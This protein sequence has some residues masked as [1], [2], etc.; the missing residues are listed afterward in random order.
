MIFQGLLPNFKMNFY[1][2]LKYRDMEEDQSGNIGKNS[3]ALFEL[4]KQLVYHLNPHKQL[5][6]LIQECIKYG[7]FINDKEKFDAAINPPS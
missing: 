1:H 7:I 5:L 2:L 4:G 3:N 6:D